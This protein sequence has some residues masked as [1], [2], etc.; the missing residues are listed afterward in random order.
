MRGGSRRKS[1]CRRC[2]HTRSG[3]RSFHCLRDIR[4]STRP[5]PSKCRLLRHLNWMNLSGRQ[6]C[7]RPPWR[8]LASRPPETPPTHPRSHPSSLRNSEERRGGR[9]TGKLVSWFRTRRRLPLWSS[10]IL[11]KRKH[12]RKPG[13]CT[14]EGGDC[15]RGGSSRRSRRSC[16]S[17]LRTG[18]ESFHCLPDIRSS[19]RPCPSKCRFLRHLNW[20]NLSDCQCCF[21][22][23]SCFQPP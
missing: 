19:T 8:P 10:P 7:F 14:Y 23:R 20:M 22:C 9:N 18:T 21:D 17:R 11:P 2:S 12:R 6:S 1:R 3:T 4:S 15:T 16:C 13:R 5:Y